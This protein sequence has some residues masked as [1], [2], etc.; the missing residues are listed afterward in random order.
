M[1]LS[2]TSGTDGSD[3]D[4][5]VTLMNTISKLTAR[6]T[7]LYLAAMIAPAKYTIYLQQ[8]IRKKFQF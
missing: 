1:V 7:D 6:R 2:Y 3:I 8:P 4:I 5:N